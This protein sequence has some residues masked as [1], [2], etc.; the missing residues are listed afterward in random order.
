MK[1]NDVLIYTLQYWLDKA[2]KIL[3]GIK[4]NSNPA[5]LNKKAVKY[6][7]EREKEDEMQY[8]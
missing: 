4:S 7:K 1:N 8:M 2:E 3:K 5:Y 6:F